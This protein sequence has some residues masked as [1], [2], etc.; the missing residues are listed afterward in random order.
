MTCWGTRIRGPLELLFEGPR[1]LATEVASVVVSL[2]ATCA[3]MKDGRNLCWGSTG[4]A[5]YER[6]ELG[7]FG[8]ISPQPL[9]LGRLRGYDGFGFHDDA[10]VLLWTVPSKATFGGPRLPV[11]YDEIDSVIDWPRPSLGTGR[12]HS[13]ELD[14]LPP[15]SWPA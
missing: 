3:S 8:A 11:I 12:A 13:A 14:G 15:T 10:G 6:D 5:G 7:V 2:G 4:R 9:E 1:V